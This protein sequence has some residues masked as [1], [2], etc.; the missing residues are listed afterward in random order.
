MQARTTRV[1][2]VAVRPDSSRRVVPDIRRSRIHTAVRCRSQC[3]Y[4]MDI[5]HSNDVLSIMV[6][7]KNWLKT[8]SLI[9]G[10]KYLDKSYLYFE[11]GRMNTLSLAD[12]YVIVGR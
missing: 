5:R 2:A 10:H 6:A 12:E 9:L 8:A 1:I 4:L 11:I 7:E 3:C